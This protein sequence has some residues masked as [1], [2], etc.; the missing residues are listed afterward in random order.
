MLTA[1]AGVTYSD[2]I[3]AR[4]SYSHNVNNPSRKMQDS[5]WTDDTNPSLLTIYSESNASLNANIID[6]DIKVWLWRSFDENRNI[7]AALG[8]GA[9]YYYQNLNWDIHDVDQWYPSNPAIPHDII[10]GPA[11]TY[12]AKIYSPYV[13]IYGKLNTSRVLLNANFGWCFVS[14]HEVDNHLLRSKVSTT[15]GTGE[16]I[17]AR[18]SAKFLLGEGLYLMSDVSLFTFWATAMQTQ[19]IYDQELGRIADKTKSTQL[20][21][22]LGVGYQF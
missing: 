22:T 16:G 14:T 15:D 4:V 19:K 5:D 1:D 7:V 2:L 21:Y 8:P 12:D 9:G 3:E 10:P 17:K 13:G 20:M 6:A 11:L 18:V